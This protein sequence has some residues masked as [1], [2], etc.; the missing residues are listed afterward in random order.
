MQQ[1]TLCDGR[2]TLIHADCL[3]YLK[4]LGDNT[5]DFILTD[6]PYFQVKKNAWDNQWPDVDAFLAWLDE[7]LMEFWRV[8]KP[9]GSLY[10][11][12][13]SKLASDAE[14]LLRQRFEVLN[15]IIW[16]KPNGPVSC[17]GEFL[18]ATSVIGS[19]QKTNSS[20][21]Y[22]YIRGEIIV[23]HH[24]SWYRHQRICACCVILMAKSALLAVWILNEAFTVYHAPAC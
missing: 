21:R 14:I 2:A 3:A 11:F 24:V 4:N 22:G 10:L 15:H 13:G 18:F 23:S 6:P 1:H 9:S 12:C 19:R 20:V 16:A 5:A 17:R 7:V 8:L